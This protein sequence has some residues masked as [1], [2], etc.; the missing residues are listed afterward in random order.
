MTIAMVTNLIFVISILNLFNYTKKSLTIVV[1]DFFSIVK[2]FTYEV[3]NITK[4]QK[5]FFTKSKT[6]L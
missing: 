5:L 2:L 3:A 6:Y 1:S 4:I